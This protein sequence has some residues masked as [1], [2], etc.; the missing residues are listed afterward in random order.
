MDQRSVGLNRVGLF[1]DDDAAVEAAVNGITSQKRCT[2]DDVIVTALA[3]DDCTQTHP[4]A[5]STIDEDAS[6]QTTDATEAIEHD[7]ANCA[8]LTIGPAT[9]A[10]SAER[11]LLDRVGLLLLLL[12]QT[13]Q[14][15][16][17][18]TEIELGQSPYDLQRHFDVE[19]LAEEV[20]GIA[21][22]LDHSDH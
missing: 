16:S 9:E 20:A 6:Q 17:G 5:A 1:V 2:L 14:V 13:T 15:D 11:K 8:F 3:H 7:I 10:S 4:C 22:S 19:I 18:G 21:V 12:D